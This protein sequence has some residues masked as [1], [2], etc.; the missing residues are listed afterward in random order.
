[1][2]ATLKHYVKKVARIILGEY[3]IFYIYART[4]DGGSLSE[5]VVDKHFSLRQV[6]ESAIKRS[7]DTLI[8][9]QVGYTGPNSYAYACFEGDRIVGICFYWFGVRYLKRNFWPL[10]DSEA[11][12][13]Q[14]V[15]LPEIRG[16]GVATMLIKFSFQ[17]IIEKGFKKVYAR[18]W[19]SNT[20]S[21]HAFERS[22]W[23][24]IALVIEI[25]P[26]RQSKPIRIR[27]N[28]AKQ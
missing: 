11:K 7:I 9:E 22:G 26:T 15:T 25:N 8:R 23:V 1:M 6:D 24:R 16:Q 20:P 4:N 27:F 21:I 3:S 28:F 12:L 2:L 13:V 19:H 17:D 10:A 18:I 14:I 5:V